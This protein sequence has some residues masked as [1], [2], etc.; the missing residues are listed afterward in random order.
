MQWR[1]PIVLHKIMMI[2]LVC[3]ASPLQ[4]QEWCDTH[5]VWSAKARMPGQGVAVGVCPIEGNC[6]LPSVRDAYIP[7]GAASFK[8]IRLHLLIF[9]ED[10]SSNA[11]TTEAS[12]AF[13]MAQLNA[14]FAPHKIRFV[15]G[16][17]WVN[18]SDYRTLSEAEVNPM[19]SAHARDPAHACNVYITDLSGIDPDL[20]G[21]GTFAWDPD[22]MTNLGGVIIDDAAFGPGQK[23]LT[24]ELGH[25]LGLWHTFHGVSELC[26]DGA[27]N[28]VP[29]DQPG[30]I[31]SGACVCP[32]Y[33]RADG[34]EGDTTG[35]FAADTPPTPKNLTCMPP[36]GIDV[37]S[38]TPEPW[39]PTQPQN[40]MGYAPDSCY[41]LFTPHQAGRMHCWI[42]A[43]LSGWLTSNWGDEFKVVA[44]DGAAHNLFGFSASISGDT[45]LIG[46]HGNHQ[47]SGTNP[48]AA[49]VFVRSG[50]PDQE[51]WQQQAKLT[52]SDGFLTD[53]FGWSVSISGDTAIVGA[54][55]SFNGAAIS[56]GAAYVFVRSGAPGSEVWT[57]QQKL[58]ASDGAVV[59]NFGAAVSI[60]GETAVIGA[61]GDNNK[62]GNNAGAAYVF[63]RSGPPGSQVWTQQAKLTA[64]D[65]SPNKLLGHSVCI[66]GDTAVVGENPGNNSSGAA[67]VFIRSGSPGSEVWTQQQKLTAS[68]G[69]INDNFGWSVSISGD[70]AL[71]GARFD[72]NDGGFAAGSTYVFA[73]SGPPGSEVWTEQ[74]KLTASDGIATD[75]FGTSVSISGDAA[76][77]GTQSVYTPRGIAGSAY[78]FERSGPTGSGIWME[79]E[80]LTASDSGPNDRFGWSV[81]ISGDHAL[82]GA[83]YDDNAGGDEAGSAYIYRLQPLSP[84]DLNGDGAVD[85]D[86]LLAVINAWGP[87]PAPCAADGNTD[88]VVDVDDLLIIINNWG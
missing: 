10:D 8:T 77:I 86:D 2:G 65:G 38:A 31:A 62:N 57:Q 70:T 26:H 33:E 82:V 36:G 50:P 63:V 53:L 83:L 48:G 45:A 71:I 78:V 20:L 60:S 21:R 58:L 41:S 19:K 29:C 27:D 88:G 85:V 64:S 74:A 80:K 56:T 37:C 13:Q 22:A 12:I 68:D 17:H 3:I 14:D 46:S 69:E 66:S 35:D 47:V 40:Y 11:A 84:G 7:G 76:V 16:Y 72:N 18:S 61:W 39:G 4:A 9:C 59:D 81:A 55:L 51:V 87:C 49:Y 30:A 28:C 23:T 32:C 24:H 25:N 34:F 54:Y 52:P 5:T 42:T 15:A 43:K 79:R 1:P 44:Q 75:N 67:Y 73:R 6:D